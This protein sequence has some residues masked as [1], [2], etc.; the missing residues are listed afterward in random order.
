MDRRTFIKAGSVGV[1]VA[2]VLGGVGWRV[3]RRGRG[4]KSDVITEPWSDLGPEAYWLK[5]N[6]DDA[7]VIVPDRPH[8]HDEAMNGG[9]PRV[10]EF[11][12]RTNADRLRG[13]PLTPAPTKTRVLAVGDSVTFGWGVEEA[14]SWPAQVQARL[15]A[16]GV[17]TEF[18]NAGVPAS[19]PRTMSAWLRNKGSALGAD[20]VLFCR[21]PQMNDFHSYA[22]EIQSAQATMPGV[23]FAVLLPPISRFDPFGTSVF[24]GEMTGLKRVLPSTPILE[25]TDPLWSAQG[26]AGV[27]LRAEPN[28]D[29]AMVDVASG[30]VLVQAPAGPEEL[31][32]AI[33]DR[34]DDDPS[35][36]EALFFDSGH[37][38][39]AGFEVFADAVVDFI[40]R[41]R[42]L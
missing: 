8:T 42:L 12:V 13:G 1:A 40:D 22:R 36:R 21:R 18:V 14:H 9:V 27:T 5:A 41:E 7:R 31:P 37:P 29:L 15:L 19:P 24:R 34:F 6:L 2:A 3:L 11:R 17:D 28:G 30:Q 23:K 32:R 25:L 35:V 33:Y 4:T 20:L 16:K 26:S 10:R 39:A 38:D